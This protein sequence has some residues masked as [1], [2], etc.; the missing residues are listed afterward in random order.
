MQRRFWIIV[1]AGLVLLCAAGLLSVFRGGGSGA[2]A[3]L[4]AGGAAWTLAVALSWRD[5]ERYLQRR[6]T[7]Y[8]LNALVLSFLVAVILVLI[9]FVADRHGWR[10]DLTSNREFSLSDKTLK[11]LQ[12]I[13]DRVDV[14]VFYDRSDR[15]RARDLLHEYTRRNGALRIH[16]DDLNKDPEVAERY[17][18][19]SLGHIVFDTGEKVERISAL[20]EE[21]VTNALIKV[22]RP[23]KKRVYFVTDHGEKD[24]ENRGVAGFAAVAEAL[25]RENYEPMVL[26]LSK[27]REVPSDCDILVVAG[28]KSRYLDSELA[29]IQRYIESG[30]RLFCMFDPRYFCGLEGYLQGWGMHVGNDRVIDPSPTGQLLGRGPS[31]PLAKSYGVH[32]ITRQFHVPTY[33]EMVRSV[34]PW[35]LYRGGAETAV[36]VYTGDQSWADGDV[37]SAQVSFGEA[38]DMAGPVPVAM[39]ARLDVAGLVPELESA[40]STPKPGD[41]R[42]DP[43]ALHA[44]EA[45]S[46]TEARIVAFGDSDFANNRNFPDMG[47]GNL[48][49][50]CIAWLAQDEDLIALRPKDPDLRS[51]SLTKAQ[52]GVLNVL[53]IGVLPGLVAAL[54]TILTLRRRA[55]S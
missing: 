51:V 4:L 9:G 50:N 34:R 49:L 53:A 27:T 8:G 46:Q 16:L 12:G 48:F 6:S 11:V 32:A 10:V 25:R 45:A 14:H 18:I 29:A 28:P 24:I 26:S 30:R 5:L 33:Y 20:S 21:D 55:R 1:G 38:D 52:I 37:T 42:I 41:A 47:N 31:T 13:H 36:L 15:D 17:G 3:L 19:T 7:R 35:N 39:A 43:E 2:T 22:S 44:A 40:V 23:G 54:G